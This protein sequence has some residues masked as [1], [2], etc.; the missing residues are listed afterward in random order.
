VKR[1]VRVLRRARRDLQE[2][3][4]FLTREAPA[5]ADAVA[6][7]ILDALESLAT[8][9][10]RGARPRDGRLRLTGFRYLAVG[11]YLVFYKTVGRT[12]RVYRILHGRRAY[13]ALL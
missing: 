8:M 12:V 6:D 4:D 5:S 13:R 9:S 10:D 1:T 7:A 2:I 11:S 3:Y